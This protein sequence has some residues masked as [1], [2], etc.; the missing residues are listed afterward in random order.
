MSTSLYQEWCAARLRALCLVNAKVIAQAEALMGEEGIVQAGVRLEAAI[1]YKVFCRHQRTLS[2]QAEGLSASGDV[3]PSDHTAIHPATSRVDSPMTTSLSRLCD[4]RA[5]IA[6]AQFAC[7]EL[8]SAVV[9]LGMSANQDDLYWMRDECAAY[10]RRLEKLVS[11][12]QEKLVALNNPL[13]LVSVESTSSRILE[14]HSPVDENTQ[15]TAR[16]AC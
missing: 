7:D 10:N 8:G 15:A 13:R 11:A 2:W 5:N 1:I 9:I 12:H 16:E 6:A 3:F 14:P 4:L